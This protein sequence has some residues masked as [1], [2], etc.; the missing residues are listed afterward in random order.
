VGTQSLTGEWQGEDARGQVAEYCR[1]VETY[2]C[3]KNDGHLIRIVGP[4]F[5]LVSAWAARGVPLR[6][7]FSGIDRCFERYHRRGPRRRPLKV[8]FCDADVLD[9]FDDWRRA[10][11][12]PTAGSSSD[13]LRDGSSKSLPLH[14]ERVLVRLTA[15][16]ANGQ[17]GD[18]F[19]ALIDCVAHELDAARSASGGLRGD[20]RRSLISRLAALDA[21]VLQVARTAIDE[22]WGAELAGEADAELAGFRAR[23]DPESF[24]RARAAAFDR[25]LRDRLGLP[26]IAFS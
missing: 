4:S 8:D 17:L 7:A 15:G 25:L 14:L 24:A 2:L 18:V 3:R 9:A 16:R 11:G 13:Q 5:D 10:V 26:A 20:A 23:M 22:R 6:I 21:E 1:E 12:L 19:D